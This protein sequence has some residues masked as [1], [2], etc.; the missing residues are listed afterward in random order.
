M[1]KKTL[2][3]GTTANDGTGD[4]LRDAAGK[5]NDNFTELF[6][7]AF[8]SVGGGGGYLTPENI[9]T[10]LELN[11]IVGDATLVDSA[12]I[13]ARIDASPGASS[14]SIEN[15]G[16]E[17]TSEATS[18]DFLG[19]GVKS[20]NSG[21]DVSVEITGELEQ[22]WVNIFGPDKPYG[23]DVWIGAATQSLGAPQIFFADTLP[24]SSKVFDWSYDSDGGDASY[25][26]REFT[27]FTDSD[28][29]NYSGLAPY[30]GHRGNRNYAGTSWPLA[31]EI[32]DH[33]DVDV[34]VTH[35]FWSGHGVAQHFYPFIDSA[36]DGEGT[37]W[38]EWAT[39]S[40]AAKTALS[41][42]K[43]DIMMFM[44]GDTDDAYLDNN[45]SCLIE[46]YYNFID[47]TEKELEVIDQSTRHV[48]YDQPNLERWY[49]WRIYRAIFE[50]YTGNDNA[51]W[52]STADYASFD[53]TH[54]IGEGQV[55][56]ARVALQTLIAGDGKAT[57]GISEYQRP[58][59]PPKQPEGLKRAA[60][61]SGSVA[62]LNKEFS[63]NA[64]QT[65]IAISWVWSEIVG[66]VLGFPVEAGS[67]TVGIQNIS[68]RCYIKI[69]DAENTD[70]FQVFNITNSGTWDNSLP[71]TAGLP[72]HKL[73]TINTTVT[74]KAGHWPTGGTGGTGLPAAARLCFIEIVQAP[75]YQSPIR[76]PRAT[77]DADEGGIR[78]NT[79]P[80]YSRGYKVPAAIDT[81]NPFGL[82]T[83]ELISSTNFDIAVPFGGI[84]LLDG[85][86]KLIDSL[87]PTEQV[88]KRQ[89]T[90]RMDQ[91]GLFAQG[92]PGLFNM[93]FGDD[94]IA[95][96]DIF[97]NLSGRRTDDYGPNKIYGATYRSLA[98]FHDTGNAF[99]SSDTFA[100]TESLVVNPDNQSFSQSGGRN[101]PRGVSGNGEHSW[102]VKG[103]D[104]YPP[105]NA[106][107]D[108]SWVADVTLVVW[109]YIEPV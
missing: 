72:N 6:A 11:A 87:E 77:L 102:T 9:N 27:G 45:M 3:I 88:Y 35:T 109:K 4:T 71:S 61:H 16:T 38:T 81:E 63:L 73:F 67:V 15:E 104:F 83:G 53:G 43:M 69:S 7:A 89:F 37:A 55:D 103:T 92:D 59:Q 39:Q 107:V 62:T 60:D 64:A 18:I 86:G 47:M 93:V 85:D 20:T 50:T 84:V 17:L 23:E 78:H 28:K 46:R 91:S 2:N 96:V 57:G 51:T 106:G 22:Q 79:V 24:E 80:V 12:T 66:Y 29:D 52:V 8:D 74:A 5:I 49:S 1:A 108:Y 101:V 95:M 54:P 98:N 33:F 25:A 65:E 26:F 42:A 56:Q 41:G 68:A 10:L 21:G 76:W 100:S 94:I 31:V 34:Y 14:L 105:A 30:T 82:T 70:N 32:A 97:V 75:G 48:F 19:R 36:G 40:S 13:Q 44:T 90:C 58:D 99:Q